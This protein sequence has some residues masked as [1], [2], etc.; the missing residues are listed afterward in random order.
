VVYTSCK[1]TK[2][3]GTGKIHKTKALLFYLNL[4]AEKSKRENKKRT[5]SYRGGAKVLKLSPILEYREYKV[6]SPKFIWAPY[7]VMCTAVLIG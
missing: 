3:A 1:G 7:H 2:F 6:R 4:R 5:T